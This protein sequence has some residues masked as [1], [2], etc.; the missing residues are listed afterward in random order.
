[1]CDPMNSTTSSIVVILLLAPNSLLA[2]MRDKI[3]IH[4]CLFPDCTHVSGA[5]NLTFSVRYVETRAL[6]IYGSPIVVWNKHHV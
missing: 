3:F 6:N 5:V 1:M 2:L 4:L